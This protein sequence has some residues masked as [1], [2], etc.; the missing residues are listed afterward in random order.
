MAGFA[1]R[2]ADLD[3]LRA[4]LVLEQGSDGAPH[5]SEAVWANL[6]SQSWDG[7]T[8][9]LALAA[10]L[11][12]ELAGFLVAG[13]VTEV[14]ELESVMVAKA[15]RG[16]GIG[17]ALCRSAMAWA[18]ENGAASMELEVRESNAAAMSLYE[19]L[20][21]AKQGRRA[22]YYRNPDEDAVLMAAGL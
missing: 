21:F 13:A 18:K 20:G 4:I 17:K 14:A 16:L 5:W 9:R 7:P 1:I 2:K 10:V 22:R 12:G 15:H 8:H 6:L 19:S 11:A 3:D